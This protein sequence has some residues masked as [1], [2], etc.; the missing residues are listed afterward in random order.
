MSRHNVYTYY[1]RTLR[2]GSHEF[3]MKLQYRV[4]F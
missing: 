2:A 4:E 3:V 1:R